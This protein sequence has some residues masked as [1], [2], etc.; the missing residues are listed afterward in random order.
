M[1]IAAAH[2]RS[3]A[4][5]ALRWLVQRG[6][7][8]IPKSVRKDRMAQNLDVFGFQLSQD[9]LARIA[10]LDLATSMFFD[11]RDPEQVARLNSL[12]RAT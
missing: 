11:H 1:A 3:V 2:G 5:V 6:V 12:H 10:A 9:E 4:Q 7:V 8:V